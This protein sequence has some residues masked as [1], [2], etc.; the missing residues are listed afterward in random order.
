M[1][2]MLHVEITD[3]THELTDPQAQWLAG[4]ALAAGKALRCTG[5]VRVRVVGDPEMARA[6]EEFA[7]VEG[8]TDVLTFD[9]REGEV[10]DPAAVLG[11]QYS[12]PDANS[13]PTLIDTD[14]M[15]CLDEARRQAKAREYPFDRELLL[16]VVH[17]MLHCLGLDDHDGEQFEAMHRLE[18]AV[19][20]VVGVGPV[21]RVP[22]REDGQ[23]AG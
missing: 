16:Y 5:A 4:H 17:G 18:D 14:I 10:Y 1:G 6:H 12:L 20:E 19:L 13:Y 9:L 21:F 11:P 23:S 2:D 22:P 15:V 8:T 7:G 3:A